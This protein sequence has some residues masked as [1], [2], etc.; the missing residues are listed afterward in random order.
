VTGPW[1]GKGVSGTLMT[2]F[3]DAAR[4]RG[5]RGIW[6]EAFEGNPRALGFYRRWGFRDLGGRQVQ[7]QDG[8]HLPHRILGKDLDLP[9]EP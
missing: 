7:V 9:R 6:L 5:A 2:A 8:V 3:L 1:Q 4:G